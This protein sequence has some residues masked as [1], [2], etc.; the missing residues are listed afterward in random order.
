MNRKGELS[1]NLE[2]VRSKIAKVANHEVNW[3]FE[4]L[5]KTAMLK[6]L[7]KQQLSLAPGIFK[8]RSKAT[9]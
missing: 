1:Q 9:S 8:A 4:I 2:L 3:E 6:A 7:K 5:V